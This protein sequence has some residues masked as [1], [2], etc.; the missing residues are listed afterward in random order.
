MEIA[1]INK[2]PFLLHLSSSAELTMTRTDP[3]LH[4]FR[5]AA[6][7]QCVPYFHLTMNNI[8]SLSFS[9]LIPPVV[10]TIAH[11]VDSKS[12]GGVKNISFKQK[13]LFSTKSK[14]RSPPEWLRE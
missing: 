9:L 4:R 6:S 13:L 14:K 3:D 10:V 7:L 2:T 11:G 12:R 1:N 5:S 8:R